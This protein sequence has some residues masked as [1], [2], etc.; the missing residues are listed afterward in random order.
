VPFFVRISFFG[1]FWK[2]CESVA[3]L[4][5]VG[6]VTVAGSDAGSLFLQLYFFL[7]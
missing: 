4:S 1:V 3:L 5:V 2:T 7:F 6:R